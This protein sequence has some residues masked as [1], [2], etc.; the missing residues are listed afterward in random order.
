MTE[1]KIVTARGTYYEIDTDR[2]IACRNDAY[3]FK[4]GNL[5]ATPNWR[6]AWEAEDYFNEHE[7]ATENGEDRIPEVGEH[8]Y[9]SGLHEWWL[10]TEVV[11]VEVVE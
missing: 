2:R 6:T 7:W 8:M 5:L 1:I 4:Y 9:I 11:S 3:T 10:S